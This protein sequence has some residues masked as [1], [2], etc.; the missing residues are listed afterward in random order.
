MQKR[1]FL[2]VALVF[3]LTSVVFSQEKKIYSIEECIQI[4][5]KNSYAVRSAEE[6]YNAAK[7]NWVGAWSGFLPK[8]NASFGYSRADVPI[9]R[10]QEGTPI[11]FSSS[12]YSWRFGVSQTIFD[13]GYNLAN[14]N[15]KSS[16]KRS[17]FDGVK[18][19]RQA[20]TLQVKENCY[21][22]LK[23]QMLYDLQQDAVK[24]SEEQLKMAK[25]RFDLGAASLSDYLKAKVQL[26]NDSL[27][28]ITY[29]N[30]VKLAQAN[31]NSNLGIDLDTPIEVAAKLEYQ[32]F[33]Q[34]L[35]RVLKEVIDS[36]PQIDQAQMEKNRAHS[37]MTIARSQRFPS[38]T[39]SLGY[40]WSDREFPES[41]DQYRS[42][43]DPWS[44]GFSIGLNIFDGFSITAQ[45][46][47]AK[48]NYRSSEENLKQQK[49]VVELE[50]RQAYLK[51]KEAEQKI[52]VAEQ[53]LSSAEED[54]KLTQEKYNLGAA[55]MLELL[56]ANVSY[57][58]AQNSTV[59][60]LYDYNLAVAQFEKAMGK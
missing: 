33:E 46:M 54:M 45:E 51:V 55:S 30:N 9:V 38:L 20:T 2:S 8:A 42:V 27:T 37:G 22:L 15:L 40:S 12:N 6:N 5:L 34:D 16:S 17:A 48:A 10:Y 7:W 1:F 47:S 35:E 57:K 19:A 43:Y 28:L 49:R 52:L 14:Y 26:G 23:T 11:S 60:A 3:L 59:Q 39:F 53:A 18:L 36:H 29:A 4:A 32:I 56:D 25:A 44:V 58:T 24:R 13:G 31:L 21:D 41:R 50:I